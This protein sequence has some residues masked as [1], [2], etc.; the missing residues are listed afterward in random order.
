[1]IVNQQNLASMAVGYSVLFNKA[2]SETP[3]NYQQIATV[4][5]STTKEQS[6]NWLGQ[7]PSMREWVGEREIQQIGAYDYPIKNKHF[8][9]TISV[10]RDDIEDDTYGAYNPLFTN[11]GQCAAE[12]PSDMCFSL[13]MN[14][15]TEKCYDGR[16]FFD[17]K[18]RVGK[19]EVSNKGTKKLGFKSYAE[20]RTAI[21]SM[22][23]DKGKS[24][25]LVPDLLVVSPENE[26]MA[27]KILEAEFIDGTSNIYKG[28]AKLLVDP[29]LSEKPS[30]WYLLCTAKAI[31]PIIYQERTKIKFVKLVNETDANVFTRNEFIYG[32]DGRNNAGYG[33]WQM[34]YG[35]TGEDEE[36]AA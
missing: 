19:K 17:A 6:Y 8:E 24:L 29:K 22:K 31:K 1:M 33:F 18:H 35:S 23:G 26:E 16:P 28:T 15:F 32:A 13:L 25:R 30:Q 34:A 2:F 12:H 11:M 27:R 9:M 21:M 20:A 3:T 5:P 4:V 14:G 7:M 10:N 36:S